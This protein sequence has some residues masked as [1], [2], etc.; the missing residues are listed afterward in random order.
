MLASCRLGGIGLSYYIPRF[1]AQAVTEFALPLL[2][3]NDLW[4]SYGAPHKQ[5]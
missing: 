2:K 4:V 5:G 3:D 1:T